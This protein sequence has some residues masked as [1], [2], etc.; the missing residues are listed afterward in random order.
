MKIVVPKK[1]KTIQEMDTV[2]L[3][4]I[5]S[6]LTFF[7][8]LLNKSIKKQYIFRISP[9]TTSKGVSLIYSHLSLICV[10]I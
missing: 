4:I 1:K 3:M 2:I 9:Y 7:E 6:K 8:N 5:F 10:K